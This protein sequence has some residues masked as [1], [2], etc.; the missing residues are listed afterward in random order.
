MPE[1]L[2]AQA[3]VAVRAFDQARHIAHREAVE[4]GILHYADLGVE[5]GEGIGR[6]FGPG[7]RDGSEQGGFAGIGI[8]DQADFG[9]DAQFQEEV[10]FVARLARLR[11]PRGLARGG[12]KVAVAQAAASALAQDET[13]AVFRQVG[14]QLSVSRGAGG[15]AVAGNGRGQ[16]ALFP[17]T[18]S[19][20]LG[21]REKPSPLDGG[22]GAFV[23]SGWARFL[24]AELQGPTSTPA[25]RTGL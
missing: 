5:G 18:P 12:G 22:A 9:H 1:K 19:L 14:D 4:V 13:L 2:V 8:T 21:E 3:D 23:V 20:S 7:A 10:A 25:C 16:N 11:E 15:G 24:G 17:L 6:D